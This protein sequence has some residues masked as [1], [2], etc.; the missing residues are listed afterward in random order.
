MMKQKLCALLSISVVGLWMVAACGPAAGQH[1]GTTA[2]AVRLSE[3]Q[4]ARLRPAERLRVVATTAIV[5]DVVKQVTGDGV[6]LTT[7]MGP[8][9]DPHSY[10]PTPMDLAAIEQAHII[11]I[12][13]LGLEEGLESTLKAAAGRNKP[14]I[15]VSAGI[16]PRAWDTSPATSESDHH[17][18]AGDPHVWFDPANVK[19][20]TSNIAASLSALDPAHADTYR[21]NA[22][23]YIGQL[24]EL[25]SHIQAQVARIPPERRKL[26]TDHDAFGYFAARYGFRIVGTVMPGTSTATEP[27]A[28]EMAALVAQIRSEGVP[29]IFVGATV[30]P[31]VAD[32]V[33]REA[34]AQVLRLY[35]GDLGPPGSGAED[36]ISMMRVDVEIIVQGLAPP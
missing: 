10:Q 32:L 15:S 24:E 19:T 8:G 6:E 12:N 23:R 28:R 35:T 30:N 25:D 2:P 17:H 9:Q 5:G 11:F 4:P 3:M 29:A 33:A 36:Y 21:A 16:A 7:L 13:G 31:K 22:A 20:W 27:S 26:V 1:A 14:V 18:E 34:G